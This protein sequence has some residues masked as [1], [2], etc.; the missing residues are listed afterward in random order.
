MENQGMRMSKQFL[1]EHSEIWGRGGLGLKSYPVSMAIPRNM[2]I[3]DRGA[4]F[5]QR[6]S[7]LLI[8]DQDSAGRR[9]ARVIV[10][11]KSNAPPPPERFLLRRPARKESA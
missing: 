11:A 6:Q 3:A 8:F 4:I 2:E 7:E 10:V 5:A 1:L 9:A